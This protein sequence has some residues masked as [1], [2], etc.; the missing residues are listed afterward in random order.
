MTILVLNGPNL[1]LLGERDAD[2]YAIETLEQ[3]H[4][5]LEQSY[6]DIDFV[7][8]QS[9]HEGELIDA[10]Q[11]AR[12]GDTDALIA[13]W[14]GFTHSSVAIRDA[15]ELLNMPKVEVHMSNIHAREEF[16]ERSVT[17][18][19][20][21]GIITGFGSDSYLLGVEAVLKLLS[22]R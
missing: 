11:S 17:G 16:R 20:M 10:V 15:L 8:V 2:T 22:K 7:Y 12:D 5:K 18:K 13:N 1:N 21:D 3:I 6:P 14:G 19:V 9:N 4:E